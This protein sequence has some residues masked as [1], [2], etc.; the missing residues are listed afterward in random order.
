MSRSAIDPPKSVR[1][2]D[3]IVASQVSRDWP[4][5]LRLTEAMLRLLAQFALAAYTSAPWL[6]NLY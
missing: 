4:E 2:L 5:T 1:V 6:Y 3:Y